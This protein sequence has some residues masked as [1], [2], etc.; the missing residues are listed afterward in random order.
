M[1]KTADGS[2]VCYEHFAPRPITYLEQVDT[3][4]KHLGDQVG[5]VESS[6]SPVPERTQ[7]GGHRKATIE[8]FV[9][10]AETQRAV[11]RLEDGKA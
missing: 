8:D 5:E 1:E 9:Y 3:H 4:R 10:Y 2:N 6:S 11:H 7:A